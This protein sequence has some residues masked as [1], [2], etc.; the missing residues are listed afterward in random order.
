M[1]RTGRFWGFCLFDILWIGKDPMDKP[2]IDN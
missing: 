2:T 1:P